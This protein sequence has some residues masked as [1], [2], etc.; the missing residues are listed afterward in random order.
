[1]N[2]WIKVSVAAGLF[3]AIGIGAWQLEAHHQRTYFD[4]LVI[5][6]NT[7]RPW[8]EAKW[9]EATEDRSKLPAWAVSAAMY[10]DGISLKAGDKG[11]STIE[12]RQRPILPAYEHFEPGDQKPPLAYLD[13]IGIGGGRRAEDGGYLPYRYYDGQSG[14][15]I[16]EQLPRRT[17][18]G[19]GPFALAAYFL[20]PEPVK[21]QRVTFL[22]GKTHV[23]LSASSRARPTAEG[24]TLS[25]SLWA[26]RRTHVTAAVDMVIGE[27]PAAKLKISHKT[28]VDVGG[29]T[30]RMIDV[31]A[32]NYVGG[33]RT[34]FPGGDR[35]TVEFSQTDT[36][37]EGPSWISMIVAAY[38][39]GD[40]GGLSI[41]PMDAQGQMLN[42]SSSV[43]EH[44]GVVISCE[45]SVDHL[46]VV[47]GAADLRVS[48][49]PRASAWERCSDEYVGHAGAL[50]EGG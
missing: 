43:I 13:W 39:Y 46:R 28:T 29:Q 2:G 5:D 10:L 18:G 1:M 8:A 49:P 37:P 17:A 45:N 15:P 34:L 41:Q 40:Q 48:A 42:H 11:R 36:H 7:P 12:L 27:G 21:V 24:V 14:T 33:G 31:T 20:T 19:D 30:V 35:M 44:F 32:R 25:S 47:P 22:D 9:K 6:A 50:P 3:G 4:R 38:P 26:L 23:P 16:R